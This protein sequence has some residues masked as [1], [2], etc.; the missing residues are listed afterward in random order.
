MEFTVCNLSPVMCSCETHDECV[1]LL[2]YSDLLH[3]KTQ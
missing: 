1:C 2:R 3:K